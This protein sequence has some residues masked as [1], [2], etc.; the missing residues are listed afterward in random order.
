M[1]SAS[2]SV[3][4]TLE[5]P[6]SAVKLLKVKVEMARW[7]DH[8]PH[9]DPAEPPPEMDI[10]SLVAWLVYLEARGATEAEINAATPMAWRGEDCPV[11][12][13]DER[14]VYEDGVITT[15]GDA[16]AC[17]L[18]RTPSDPQVASAL[19][20]KASLV[21]APETE[22]WMEDKAVSA[23][24]YHYVVD[25]TSL[26]RKLGL[27][28]GPLQAFSPSTTKQSEDCAE[29]FRRAQKRHGKK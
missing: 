28:T 13:H 12:I 7:A 25:S 5:L 8:L 27:Y 17:R 24:R 29:C 6:M 11:L 1:A 21:S 4:V 19:E 2:K 20:S 9:R 22:G 10:G 15:I 18:A 23:R 26:C 14:R 16:V 3:R